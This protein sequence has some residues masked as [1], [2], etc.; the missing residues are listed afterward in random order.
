MELFLSRGYVHVSQMCE[1]FP[2]SKICPHVGDRVE[3]IDKPNKRV[4]NVSYTG[5][6]ACVQ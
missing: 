5:N 2:L 1:A 6:Q 3:K 4:D